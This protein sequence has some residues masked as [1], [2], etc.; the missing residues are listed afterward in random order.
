L[1]SLTRLAAAGAALVAFALA[2][3]SAHA[4]SIA[5]VK[6]GDVAGIRGIP[7]RPPTGL[8]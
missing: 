1:R 8:R 2:A 7:R 6:D 4:D 5:Y 3:P